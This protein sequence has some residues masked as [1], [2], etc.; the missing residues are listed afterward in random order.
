MRAA[1]LCKFIRN[2]LITLKATKR[3]GE[4]DNN[5]FKE[6]TSIALLEEKDLYVPDASPRHKRDAG[7]TAQWA[8]SLSNKH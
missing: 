2:L 1:Q 3:G 5:N 8:A 6:I 4:L 7:D